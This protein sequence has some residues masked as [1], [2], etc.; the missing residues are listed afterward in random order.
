MRLARETHVGAVLVGW[1]WLAGL[2]C[3]NTAGKGED[4]IEGQTGRRVVSEA[5]I[6]DKLFSGHHWK[7][8]QD[9][10]CFYLLLP[11][12]QRQSVHRLHWLRPSDV[13]I[14]SA[15]SFRDISP[16]K[17]S[18][19]PIFD[20]KLWECIKNWN[21]Q[22]RTIIYSYKFFSQFAGSSGLNLLVYLKL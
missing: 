22:S 4:I 11:E 15:F 7:V 20:S 1:W 19:F 9:R 21:C 18:R 10:T 17:N 12:R 13:R 5:E 14:P 8:K 2:L 6:S 3:D 16:G